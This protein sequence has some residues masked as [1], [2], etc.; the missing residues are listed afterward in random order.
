MATNYFSL[1]KKTINSKNEILIR[2]RHDQ[3][4]RRAK[5]GIFIPAELWDEK[6]GCVLK[7]NRKGRPTIERLKLEEERKVIEASII[8]LNDFI[9]ESF[10]EAGAG[11]NEIPETWLQDTIEKWHEKRNG[12]A[13]RHF[14]SEELGE[15]IQKT[16]TQQNK[17]YEA[18]DEFILKHKLSPA[19]KRH[20]VCLKGM[21]Q[22]FQAYNGIK[23]TFERLDAALLRSF[24]EY[25]SKEYTLY[26]NGDLTKA[27]EKSGAKARISEPRGKHYITDIMKRFRAFVRWANGISKTDRPNEIY[28]TNNPFE[29]YPIHDSSNAADN[30][31]PYFL[32][33]EERRLLMETELSGWLAR[34]RDVFVFQCV[35]GCRVG[36]LF[37]LKKSNVLGDFIE[38]IPRKT[39]EN[40]PV[41]VR[42]PLNET[43]KV[44][45]ERYKEI[46]GEKL[47]PVISEQK[48]NSAIKQILT[49]AGITRLVTVI[50]PK[51]GEPVQR[52]INEIASSHIARRTFI[53][54][55]YNQVQDPNII[56]KLS[57]HKE[58]SRAF[59]R[60]RNIG[61]GTKIKIVSLL[62]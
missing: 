43:A 45:V 38:Y 35:I 8:E 12:T 15:N 31:T 62:D 21:L 49:I 23:I 26:S 28:T 36:D 1:S 7:E 44:I 10:I 51:T 37:K 52:P 11:K 17:F 4:A 58:G 46:E 19:R 6:N 48:Y 13:K 33:I 5:T 18:L 42:V 20:Y 40:N 47:L 34:Q 14:K 57:G 59:A 54:N 32:T 22:R 50:D 55:L 16:K 39:K 30:T 3:L 24:E 9:L 29:S 53:G 25:L 2:F 27:I 61:D 60:Y 41:V 56:G